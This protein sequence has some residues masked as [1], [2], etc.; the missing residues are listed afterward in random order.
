MN[1]T[2]AALIA[3]LLSISACNRFDKNTKTEAAPV[4]EKTS[5]D[6]PE[7]S[8]YNSTTSWQTQNSD[9]LQLKELRGK[10]RVVAM[11]YT[12]C[13]YACPRLV[14][15]MKSIESSLGDSADE[16]GFVLASIDTRNDTPEKLKRFAI[17]NNLGSEWLLL[18]GSE[19]DILELAAMLGVQ[20]QR[21]SETDF[22]HSNV[23]SV[24]NED[25]EIVYQQNGLGLKDETVATIK[26]LVT[27]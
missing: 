18:H 15:D 8:I 1:W 19:N 23:L 20:Y 27:P 2:S 16:I 24:L 4:S 17:E 22:A 14:A 10:I 7:L 21:S 26:A 3:L 11:M 25:G 5:E 6:L 12:N 13:Q 9:T